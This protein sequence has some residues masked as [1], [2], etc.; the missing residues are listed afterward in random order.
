MGH[1]VRSLG[2]LGERAVENEVLLIEHDVPHDAFTA[3]VNDCLPEMPWT[4]TE[5]D[6]RVRTDLRHL[7]ICSV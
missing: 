7:D 5:H 4:I 3:A 2:A 6:R 1:Y